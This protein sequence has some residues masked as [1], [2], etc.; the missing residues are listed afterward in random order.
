MPGVAIKFDADRSSYTEKMFVRTIPKPG[1]V[2]GSAEIKQSDKFKPGDLL[3]R[4]LG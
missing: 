2:L 4:N 3:S 1:L